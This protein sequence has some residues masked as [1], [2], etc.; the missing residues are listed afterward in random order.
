MKKLFL[1]LALAAVMVFSSCEGNQYPVPQEREE[2]KIMEWV[3][4]D[5]NTSHINI[6]DSA[7]LTMTLNDGILFFETNGIE[8]FQVIGEQDTATGQFPILPLVQDTDNLYNIALDSLE[9]DSV[10]NAILLADTV[11]IRVNFVY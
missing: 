1:T 11:P 5:S 10:K 2:T 6:T 4:T 3:R 7:C 9:G 8:R